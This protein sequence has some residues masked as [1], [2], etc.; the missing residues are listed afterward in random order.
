MNSKIRQKG[1]AMVE[2]AVVMIT[3]VIVMFTPFIGSDSVF[4]LLIDGFKKN[5]AAFMYALSIPN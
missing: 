4:E 5:Y 1:A 3:F 2:Y